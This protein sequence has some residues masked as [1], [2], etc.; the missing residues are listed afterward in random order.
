M[1]RAVTAAADAAYRGILVPV[2]LYWVWFRKKSF[3]LKALQALNQ[4]GPLRFEALLH[5]MGYPG[6]WEVPEDMNIGLTKSIRIGLR[7]NTLVAAAKAGTLYVE[8]D[9]GHAKWSTY[10]TFI[11]TMTGQRILRKGQW[12]G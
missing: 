10:V 1:R 7:I 9:R 2:Y 11:I 5:I 3:T 8:Y 4:H 12:R 6:T